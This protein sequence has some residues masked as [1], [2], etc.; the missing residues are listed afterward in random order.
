[1]TDYSVLNL[2]QTYLD[3][4]EGVELMNRHFRPDFK[5]QVVERW[6]NDPVFH[7]KVSLVLYN[8]RLETGIELDDDER[9]L[10]VHAAG[11]AFIMAERVA[12]GTTPT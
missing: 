7:A 3:T 2:P 5:N 4:P 9:D 8:M 1:M 6:N 11:V 12:S 10:V